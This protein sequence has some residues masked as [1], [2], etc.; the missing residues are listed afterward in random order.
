VA[1][2]ALC[3]PPLLLP[4]TSMAGL[5]WQAGLAHAADDIIGIQLVHGAA[6]VDHHVKPIPTTTTT[7]TAIDLK[8]IT[9][10]SSA[11]ETMVRVPVAVV[12]VAVRQVQVQVQV[13]KRV[14]AVTL[15]SA[16]ADRGRAA[17]RACN[18]AAGLTV[19]TPGTRASACNAASR[20]GLG[21][22]W[23]GSCA[24]EAHRLRC[25]RLT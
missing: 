3:L 14:V 15:G 11:T 21:R 13:I 2:I 1:I 6:I 23:A 18:V 8:V 24:C 12:V 17:P 19:A 25:T 10:T 5:P 16:D 20:R 7:T 9:V 22:A 4:L